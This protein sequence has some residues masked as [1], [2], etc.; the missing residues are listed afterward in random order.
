ML[1][2]IL[3]N[4]LVSA[5]VVLLILNW[6]ERRQVENVVG[7][8]ATVQVTLPATGN[9][10]SAPVAAETAAPIPI[11]PVVAAGGNTTYVVQAGD[12]LGSISAQFD[13][14]MD[15]IIE[16]NNIDNP[17]LLAVGQQLTIPSGGD[18]G[19][20]SPTD[21]LPGQATE[22]P[23]VGGA[24]TPIPLPTE[25]PSAGVVIVEITEVSGLGTLDDE[26]I[27]VANFGDSSVA[28]LGWKLVDEEGHQFTFG[29]VTLFGE[30]AAILIHTGT[31][32]D[33]PTDLFWGL[34]E[35]IWE[36]GETATLLD[37][38]GTIQAS[39]VIP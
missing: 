35:A 1:P 19:V 22:P 39:F 7:A 8:A 30:G 37:A 5:A 3:I 33:G 17:D 28:L 20:D 24:P 21:E 4:I 2:F 10:T 31:G 34:D 6:W 13:V 15:E 27:A 18:A 14:S 11:S 36:S 29:Q 32:I 26:T 25:P 23:P 9:E 38:A 12:T 16:A